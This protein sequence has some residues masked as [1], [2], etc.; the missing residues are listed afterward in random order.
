LSS[1]VSARK[2]ANETTGPAA[3]GGPRNGAVDRS[4]SAFCTVRVVS[5]DNAVVSLGTICDVSVVNEPLFVR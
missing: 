4:S 3:G 5:V 2:S 1:P